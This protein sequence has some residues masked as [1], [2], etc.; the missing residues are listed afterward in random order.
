[1]KTGAPRLKPPVGTS[2]LLLKPGPVGDLRVKFILRVM[3]FSFEGQIDFGQDLL[4]FSGGFLGLVEIG[5]SGFS[6]HRVK[7]LAGRA[8]G[9]AA[10][11]IKNGLDFRAQPK[12]V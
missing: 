3:F 4:I 6:L 9:A 5:Q 1:M 12:S 7:T 11:R 8:F 2:K 10:W